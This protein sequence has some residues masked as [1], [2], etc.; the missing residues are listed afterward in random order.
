MAI[1]KSPAPPSRSSLLRRIRALESR[2]EE[3]GDEPTARRSA[4]EDDDP[5][6]EVQELIAS[7]RPMSAMRRYREIT[8]ASESEARDAIEQLGG[9]ASHAD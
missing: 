8:G 5:A 2:L 3:I 1:Q 7:G 9:F 6:A 4:R